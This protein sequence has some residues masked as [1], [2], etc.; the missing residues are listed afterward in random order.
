MRWVMGGRYGFTSCNTSEAA[1]ARL[2]VEMGGTLRTPAARSL[3]REPHVEPSHVS[4]AS[5][6]SIAAEITT[7]LVHE[8]L[9]THWLSY[10]NLF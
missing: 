7:T 6:A 4:A 1:I 8:S 5:L 3:P 2:F 9:A 10:Y